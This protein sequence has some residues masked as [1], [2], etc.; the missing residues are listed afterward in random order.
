V[1]GN[2]VFDAPVLRRGWDDRHNRAR[3]REEL[4]AS[5]EIRVDLRRRQMLDHHA[6]HDQVGLVRDDR[7][8]KVFTPRVVA[9]GVNRARRGVQV[10]ADAVES[11]VEQHARDV[12]VAR[13]RFDEA[14]KPAPAGRNHS[15][16]RELAP[17][18]T[19]ELANSLTR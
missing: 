2:L 5:L 10:E 15:P 11:Q 12:P 1:S 4:A 13:A 18:P 8:Q 16:T 3:R 14:V 6:G 9:P 7:R 17:S 19:R